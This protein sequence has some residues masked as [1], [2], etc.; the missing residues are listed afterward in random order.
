L[1]VEVVGDNRGGLV[2]EAIPYISWGDG[3]KPRNV[4]VVAMQP[5]FLIGHH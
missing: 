4:R 3:E 1:F 2:E 5:E